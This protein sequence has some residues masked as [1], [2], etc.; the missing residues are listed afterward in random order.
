MPTNFETLFG[1]GLASL[2][3]IQFTIHVGMNVGLLPV[4]GL[5]LPFVSYGGSHLLASFLGLG[6]LVGMS[7]DGLA[8][9]RSGSETEV[10]L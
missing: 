3:V 9:R 2:F 10:V 1:M 5:T 8:I 7:R 6:I 4:T